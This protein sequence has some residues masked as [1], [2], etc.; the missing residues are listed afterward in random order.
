M[1]PA[2][3]AIAVPLASSALSGAGSKKSAKGAS[4][5]IPEPFGSGIGT[6]IQFITQGLLGTLGSGRSPFPSTLAGSEA[7]RAGIANAFSTLT[8]IADTGL[9]AEQIATFDKQLDPFFDRLTDRGIAGVREA[10]AAGGRFFG[11]GGVGAEADFLGNVAA[12]RSAQVLPLALQTRALQGQTAAA[13][14]GFLQEEQQ[15][16]LMFI[17]ALSQLAGGAP[18]TQNPTSQNFLQFLGPQ[19][20]NLTA[21]I[22]SA[23]SG[24]GKG[25]GGGGGVK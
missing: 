12:N 9:D 14:P 21:G 10:E 15:L 18:I 20:G 7:G 2:A 17:Q 11:S 5:S 4:A 16:P 19:T 13:I 1:P 24:K 22:S 3:G 23:V 6:A 25:G 8:R